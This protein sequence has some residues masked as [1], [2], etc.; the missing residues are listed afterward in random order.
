APVGRYSAN[1]NFFSTGLTSGPLYA[2]GSA[3]SGGNGVY[4]YGSGGFPT[5]SWNSA[6]YWVDVVFTTSI[7]PDTTPP[8]APGELN[9]TA[10]SATQ[11]SLTWTASS[12]NVAVNGYRVERCQGEG[13]ANFV[14]IATPTDASFADSG[15]T[16]AITYQY[17]V[18]A[19]DAA[20]NLSAYSAVTSATTQ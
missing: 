4:Q 10:T 8:T 6:N 1:T 15:L 11:I 9:A 18:R 12:D 17:R 5:S 13:C 2:F 7:G 14:E 3:E 19:T 16:E 20:G